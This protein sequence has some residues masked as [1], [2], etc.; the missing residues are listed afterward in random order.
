MASVNTFFEIYNKGDR[1]LI[2]LKFLSMYDIH[3]E[4]R[5]EVAKLIDTFMTTNDESEFYKIMNILKSK[6]EVWKRIAQ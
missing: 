5:S 2:L 3:P 6:R 1:M 4:Y